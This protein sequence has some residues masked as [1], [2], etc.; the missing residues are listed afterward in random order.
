MQV[1]AVIGSI[2][3]LLHGVVFPAFSIVF[4]QL[5]NIFY[6]QVSFL[7]LSLSMLSSRF[8]LQTPDE[9]K[10][11]AAYIAAAFVGIAVYNLVFGYL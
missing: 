5:F 8:F 7:V 1:Y 9:I 4:G 3:A 2:A 10:S 11:N 6:S